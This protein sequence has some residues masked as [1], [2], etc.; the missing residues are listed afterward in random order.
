MARD[1]LGHHLAL[2]HGAVRQHRLA[3]DVADGEDSAHRGAALVVD[4]DEFA[5]HIE[6][7]L[8]QPPA[9]G[10]RLAADRDQDLVGR[11]LGVLALDRLDQQRVALG[12]QTFGVGAGHHLDTEL[13]EPLQHRPCQLGVI[14]RQHARQGLD[15]GHLG[16]HLG[17]RHAELQPD[18]AAADHGELFRHIAQ[19]Q[20]LGRRDDRTAEGQERQFHRRR[21][22][23]DHHRLGADD[24]GPGLG[25]DLDGLA[26]PECRPAM[27][28]LDLRLL[29]QSGNTAIQPANDTVFPADRSRQVERRRADLDAEWVL[30]AGHMRDLV[31][32]FRRMDER[33]GRDAADIEAG[34]TRLAGFDDDGVDAELSGA[35]GADIAAG[36]GADDEQL[37]GDFFHHGT[38]FLVKEDPSS[39]R[40]AATF[41]PRGE[42][43]SGGAGD[44]LSPRGEVGLPRIAL[45]NSAG[46]PGEG[47]FATIVIS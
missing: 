44:L 16:A 23:S 30:A 5:R 35:D 36:T 7:D 20:R 42:E 37:A 29:Q 8:L 43:D 15:H 19:R 17:E 31:E 18:I 28:G 39:G 45:R 14:L 47:A 33:L 10:E 25:L 24:L 34:A 40:F 1:D 12:R 4:A 9:R 26:V 2:R 32:L 11:D 21:A 22:G 38:L 41:S 27:H 46:D 3:G 13:A 6:V